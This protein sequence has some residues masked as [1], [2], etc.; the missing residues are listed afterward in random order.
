MAIFIV[1]MGAGAMIGTYVFYGHDMYGGPFAVFNTTLKWW[2]WAYALV[3][4]L[5][6]GVCWST[7][8]LRR[9]AMGIVI[10]TLVGNLWIFGGSWLAQPK[11][12]LGRLDGY[13]WFTDAEPEQRAIIEV[14][15]TLPK[16][17]VM[18]SVPPNPSGPCITIAQFTGHYSLGGWIGH[19]MLWRGARIDL[20]A[21]GNGRDAFYNSQLK[22][23]VSWLN[24]AMPGGVN[25]IVWL[26]RDS[27]R[28]PNNWPG[29][30]DSIKSAYDWKEINTIGDTHWGIWVRK[31]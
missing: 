20:V 4:S 21:L 22:D 31:Y 1:V 17:V 15:K 23:P 11:T 12:H 25:Y 28:G 14:L 16:G 18:E 3:L 8:L 13:A 5:G 27:A 30:N 10:L 7:L 24:A 9:I 29:V 6:I 19:E 2:P 26:D